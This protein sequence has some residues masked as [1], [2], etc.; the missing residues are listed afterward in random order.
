MG[1]NGRPLLMALR[2]FIS[3]KSVKNTAYT[4]PKNKYAAWLTGA[5]DRG[6]VCYSGY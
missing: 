6:E 5:R 2:I 1:G 3:K 4:R